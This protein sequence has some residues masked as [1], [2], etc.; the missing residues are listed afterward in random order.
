MIEIP[1][2]LLAVSLTVNVVCG[3]GFVAETLRK[4]KAR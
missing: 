2:W 4:F 1:T 3:I